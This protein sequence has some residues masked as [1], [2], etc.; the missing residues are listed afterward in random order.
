MTHNN[1]LTNISIEIKKSFKLAT[2]LFASEIIYAL[3]GFIITT[4][5]AGIGKEYLAANALVWNIYI[6][7]ILFT[8]GILCAISTMVSQSFGAN[9]NLTIGICFKQGAILAIILAVPIML[10]L[11]LV[12]KFLLLTKQDPMLV[13]LATPFFYSL[14][15]AVPS[16]NILVLI[17]QLLIGIG[18]T[19]IVTM[20]SILMTPLQIGF[21]YIFL[22]GY[23]GCPKLRLEGIGYSSALAHLSVAIFFIFYIKFNQSLRIY[24]LTKEFWV[25]NKKVLFEL[26]RIGLPLGFTWCI[27]VAMLAV[28]AIMMGMFGTDSLAAYQITHQYIMLALAFIFALTQTTTVRIGF[29]VGENNKK[30]LKLAFLVNMAMGLIFMAIFALGFNIF[31]KLAIGLDIDIHAVNLQPIVKQATRFLILAGILIVIEAVRLI[32][33]GALRGLK[34]TKF[35]LFTSIIG[36]WLIAIPGAYLL[37]FK[38]NLGGIGIYTGMII[39]MIATGAILIF[40]FNYIIKKID[41]KSLV[42]KA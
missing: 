15:W 16:I 38:L 22:H 24:N 33:M 9:D 27:E 28:I 12:P 14:I 25:I 35:I 40:R 8:V 20:I 19:R 37:A 4:M 5:L 3:S 23:F 39:G 6:A 34:D 42:T 32:A 7:I 11:C 2:P 1:Y 26:I 31:A 18:K 41:L 17:E 29:E 21:F 13:K 10:I 36:F 30:S